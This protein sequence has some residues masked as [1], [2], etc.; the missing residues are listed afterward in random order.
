[1]LREGLRT[2]KDSWSLDSGYSSVVH[3]TH[4]DSAPPEQGGLLHIP[5]PTQW[6]RRQE[7]AGLCPVCSESLDSLPDVS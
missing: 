1:M 3:S 4:A 2:Q 5:D 6:L 7:A